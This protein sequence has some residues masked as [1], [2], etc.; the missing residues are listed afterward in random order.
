MFVI[1]I[2][3]TRVAQLHG[4]GFRPRGSGCNVHNRSGADKESYA[5]LCAGCE[6]SERNGRGLSDHHVVM[7][8]VRLV[9]TWIKRR[10]VVIESRKLRNEKLR[11]QQYIE[12][13]V[14]YFESKKLERDERRNVEHIWERVKRAVVDSAR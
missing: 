6:S 2:S 1:H 10:E 5:A 11:E 7:C 12:E 9:G 3:S 8:K 14:R 4:S 13:Y